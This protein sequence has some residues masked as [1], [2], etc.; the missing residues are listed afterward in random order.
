ML[1]IHSTD[2]FRHFLLKIPTNLRIPQ[3]YGMAK[4]HKNKIPVPM[5]PVIS[6]CGSFTAFISIWLDTILQP[7]KD[8]LPS[9]IKD[10]NSLLDL[11][12]ELPPL[13]KSARVV[14]TDDVSMYTNIGTE[15]GIATIRQYLEKYSMEYNE[16]FP[17]DLVCN[18]LE[19][20]MTNNIFQFGNTWWKQK[21]GTA[22]GTPCACIYATLFFGYHERNLLLPKY[23]NNIILYKQQI[24]DILLVWKPTSLNNE[25]WK[26]FK[27]DLNT[28]SSLNWETEDLSDRTH[29]LDLNIWIDNKSGLL[30]YNT[31]QKPMNLF[32]YIPT[33]SAHP[34]NTTKSLIYGLLQTYRRQNP[35]QK[36]FHR[37]GK[38]LFQRLRARGHTQETLTT[39]FKEA[40]RKLNTKL[41]HNKLQPPCQQHK[42][43]KLTTTEAI[44]SNLFLH[45]Q[46]H[47]KGISRRTIQETYNKI[48]TRQNKNDEGFDH[49]VNDDTDGIMSV[50]K[51]TVACSRPRNIRDLLCPSTLREFD[52]STVSNIS[53]NLLE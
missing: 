48:C 40:L 13:P 24:D 7:L 1:D 21:N 14:T 43:I 28:C 44:N 36:D 2:F 31:Y 38:L 51:L 9:Y 12:D 33:H 11:I 41:N 47:P 6:Q 23:K 49:M 20:V 53:T 18:L 26:S 46:Y 8:Y 30:K 29:F 52:A 4:V 5:R 17:T 19:I 45:L 25:E 34:K 10:S 16:N 50:K 37:M 27:H 39:L 42:R 32:L 35:D 22:M 3:F 15:E